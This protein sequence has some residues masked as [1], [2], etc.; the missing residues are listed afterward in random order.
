[1]KY[2]RFKFKPAGVGLSITIHYLVELHIVYHGGCGRIPGETGGFFPHTPTCICLAGTMHSHSSHTHT[3]QLVLLVTTP[4]DQMASPCTCTYSSSAWAPSIAT[5]GGMANQLHT[6]SVCNKIMLTHC[7]MPTYTLAKCGTHS[8]QQDHSC[9]QGDTYKSH[10]PPL[11]PTGVWKCIVWE[12]CL[13][14]VRIRNE[15]LFWKF[16]T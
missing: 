15:R 6:C 16:L 9:E 2:Q 11:Q 3:M 8:S 1:M 7:T 10:T 12:S 13:V 14:L 4:S 5:Q